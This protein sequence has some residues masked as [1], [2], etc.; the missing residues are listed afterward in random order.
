M[1]PGQTHVHRIKFTPNRILNGEEQN[2]NNGNIKGL[3]VYTMMVISGVPCDNNSTTTVSTSD[4]KIDFVSRKSYR[5]KT[6]LDDC[7][8]LTAANNLSVIPAAQEYVMNV[9]SGAATFS[10]VYSFNVNNDLFHDFIEMRSEASV[11]MRSHGDLAGT[12]VISN[13]NSGRVRRVGTRA[14][15]FWRTFLE[16]SGF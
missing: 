10:K 5:F 16:R 15:R 2:N 14:P 1:A 8:R 4:G 12:V 9:E 11:P 7:V 3:T 6:I 13:P